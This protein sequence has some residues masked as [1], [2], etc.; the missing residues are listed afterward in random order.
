MDIIQFQLYT[1]ELGL[2]ILVACVRACVRVCVRECAC[3][4]IIISLEFV[5]LIIQVTIVTIGGR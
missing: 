2:S 4:C 1:S 3:V 5:L